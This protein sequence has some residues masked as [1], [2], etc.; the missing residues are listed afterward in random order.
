MF[1]IKKLLKASE[2]G[3][4]KSVR[5]ILSK[6]KID[7]NCNDILLLIY[8]I[9][10]YF[11]HN[12][13]NLNYFWDLIQIFHWTPLLFAAYRGHTE[14]VQLLLEQPNIREFFPSLITFIST[15]KR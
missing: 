3:D 5:N 11:F 15:K 6:K 9:I 7:I 14:I 13:Q 4:I 1:G 8:E 12:I 10:L 2:N